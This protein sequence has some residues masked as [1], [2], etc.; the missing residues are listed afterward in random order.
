MMVAIQGYRVDGDGRHRDWPRLG[1]IIDVPQAEARE[2]IHAEMAVPGDVPLGEARQ[3]I[4]AR[5]GSI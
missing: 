3:W 5:R 2:L 1:D 4:D